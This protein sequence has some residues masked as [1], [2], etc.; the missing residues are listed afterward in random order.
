MLARLAILI[1]MAIIAGVIAVWI[2]RE[3]HDPWKVVSA[4]M[5]VL[6]AVAWFFVRGYVPRQP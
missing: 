5:V 3:E 2:C 4:A 6:L 1:M